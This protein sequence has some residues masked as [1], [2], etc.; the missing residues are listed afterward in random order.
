MAVTASA[1]TV[2]PVSASTSYSQVDDPGSTL[3]WFTAKR[4]SPDFVVNPPPLP[5]RLP[6]R[7]HDLVTQARG[8]VLFVKSGR[9]NRIEIRLQRDVAIHRR[10]HAGARDRQDDAGPVHRPAVPCRPWRTGCAGPGW[11]NPALAGMAMPSSGLF[12]ARRWSKVSGSI[13][14]VNTAWSMSTDPDIHAAIEF[15]HFFVTRCGVRFHQ[16]GQIHDVPASVQHLVVEL[17]RAQHAPP[18]PTPAMNR[19]LRSTTRPGRLLR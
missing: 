2:A 11:P 4:S 16:A 3:P 13:S 1:V 15:E 12:T 6:V 17:D 9:G 10:P 14:S 8:F 5:L 18:R 7:A 19:R